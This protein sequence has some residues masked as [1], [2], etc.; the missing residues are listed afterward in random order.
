MIKRECDQ[1]ETGPA[2]YVKLVIVLLVISYWLELVETTYPEAEQK[3]TM[4][5]MEWSC[6][7]H[8]VGS[9]LID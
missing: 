6:Y 4:S 3:S 1:E 5:E 9:V 7:T 2:M 8:G